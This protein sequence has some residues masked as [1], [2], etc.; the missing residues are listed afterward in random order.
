[1]EGESKVVTIVMPKTLV[2]QVI[3]KYSASHLGYHHE[4][5][6]NSFTTNQEDYGIMDF[7]LKFHIIHSIYGNIYNGFFTFKISLV[8]K[9]QS[10]CVSKQKTLKI[11]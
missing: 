8:Y 4:I 5:Y 11:N 2:C 9:D 1:M 6:L 3:F 7:I 10:L